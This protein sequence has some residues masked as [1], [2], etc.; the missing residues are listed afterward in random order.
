LRP[1]RYAA[2]L[3][4]GFPQASADTRAEPLRALGKAATANR[5]VFEPNILGIEEELARLS[6]VARRAAREGDG[7]ES[8]AESSGVRLNVKR[9]ATVGEAD[10]SAFHSH[11]VK[12]ARQLTADPV[13]QLRL[14]QH[15]PF[16]AERAQRRTCDG[17]QAEHQG[18]NPRKSQLWH[19]WRPAC[20]FVPYTASREIK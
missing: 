6:V 14:G 7:R 10:R 8:L 3:L 13:L 11:A 19:G 17:K 5:E 18:G 1:P 4:D 12:L 20:E 2:A 15:D 16:R 9:D